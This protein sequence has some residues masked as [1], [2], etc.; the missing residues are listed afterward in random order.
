MARRSASPT[1]KAIAF[2]RKHGGYAK[3]PGESTHAAKNRMARAL[4]RAEAE[5]SARGWRVEWEGDP[6]GASDF[7]SDVRM[8]YTSREEEPREILGAVLR[9]EEGHVLSSLWGIEDPTREYR[10]VVEAELALEALG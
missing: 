4:A 7:E 10:R 1:A 5:A 9:D 8:G 2:F 3:K 6:E